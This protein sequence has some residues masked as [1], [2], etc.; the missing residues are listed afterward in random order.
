[1]AVETKPVLFFELPTKSVSRPRITGR[2]IKIYLADPVHTYIASGD[3]HR[4][5]PLNVLF[6]AGYTK[7][8]FGP[9]V[10]IHVFKR[11]DKMVEAIAADAPDIIGVS[12]YIWNYQVSK[13]LLQLARERNP[14][15]ISVMGGPNVDLDA[16]SMTRVMA[17][18]GADFY[19]PKDGET[20]FKGLVEAVLEGTEPLQA[21]PTVQGIWW[22]DAGSQRAI[23]KPA[24]PVLENLDEIPSPF[25]NGSADPF[26]MD[27]FAAT[28]DTN[29]GCPFSCTFCVWGVAEKVKHFSLERVQA[30]LDYIANT[31]A[32]ELLMINDANF[33]L[34]KDRDL[35]IANQLRRL[36]KE[37]NWPKT[38]VVN[39]G[40]V[41]S[42]VALQ[43]ADAM[44][45]IS[46]LRQSSQSMSEEVLKTIKRRNIPDK[47]W[48][49]VI[50]TCKE[51]GID[52]FAE[53]IILL[54]GE[55]LE[56]YLD[57]V[58]YFFGLKVD[59]ITTNQCQLLMGAALNSRE[60]REKHGFVSR[61]R[62]LENAYGVYGGKTCL[63]AEEVVV[64][65]KTF[66][67]EENIRCR[68]MNW[69]VQMSWTLKR[70][71]PF[72][73]ALMEL[74]IN[75]VDFFMAAIRLQDQAP[76]PIQKLFQKFD[77]DARAELFLTHA[78]LEAHYSQP[79]ILEDL[80]TGAFS[81]L[82][83]RFA[84]MAL[85]MDGIITD[86][87]MLVAR[88]LLSQ[89]ADLPADWERRI[90]ACGVL[91]HIRSLGNDDLLVLESGK[92][93]QKTVKLEYDV[94]AWEKAGGAA[95]LSEFGK[96]K[97]VTYLL[98]TDQEQ[99]EAIR[100]HMVAFSGLDREYQ[101]RKLHEP[102]YGIRKEHLLFR[103]EYA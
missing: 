97:G 79:N 48:R 100:R 73:E 81:K 7:A 75:P 46:I 98:F 64:E 69:L 74:G 76:L 60:E 29:R 31:G 83:T 103:L 5:I 19:V 12:N 82:N 49:S 66:S 2:P 78:D 26:L 59:S 90:S 85:L 63:E 16:D 14:S 102:F 89:R 96:P 33:G 95:P 18:V 20:P 87:Y 53:L 52:S 24:I 32:P 71:R 11:P 80:R 17:D 8:F 43:V 56:S 65:T 25:L 67:F 88:Q 22:W 6:I 61:W 50:A 38:V 84:G 70:H 55:T 21:H 9:K 3:T 101:L 47:Q 51:Q 68:T 45:G 15:V 40:Q 86:Y 28:L 34:F 10:D 94:V 91:S 13:A 37:K 99:G 62:L 92:P 1:M 23:E 77:R 72:L 39:W 58:R 42:E 35:A 36:N 41:R 27:G 57:G 54:P 30:E 44:K 4:F 93:V